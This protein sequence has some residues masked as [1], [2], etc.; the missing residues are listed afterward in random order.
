LTFILL[1]FGS[2]LVLSMYIPKNYFHDKVVLLIL[3]LNVF[4]AIAGS[5]L[6]LLRLDSGDTGS[7]IVQYRANLGLNA[8]EAGGPL[9]FI[10]FVVLALFVL[11][12]HTYLSMR[13][14]HIRKHFSVAILGLATLLL[15]LVI[16]VTNALFIL[17]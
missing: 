11:L 17:R 12:F 2:T 3:S 15:G 4:L 5:L 10:Y 8:F 1:T 16:I 14:Y 6:I 7:Y 9:N 13:V